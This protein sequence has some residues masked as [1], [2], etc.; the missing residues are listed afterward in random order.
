MSKQIIGVVSS[1]KAD[2]TIVILT[3]TRQTH[4]IYRKQYT[5]STKFMAHDEKNEAKD[6]DVVMISECRPISA[7]KRFKLE[8]VIERAA[9]TE[10][11]LAAVKVEDSGKKASK[12]KAKDEI[13]PME[14]NQ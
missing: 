4:P 7:K 10:D 14:A 6:G 3:Q 5:V 13:E 12:S 1:T 9:L 8:K 2:K 11:T